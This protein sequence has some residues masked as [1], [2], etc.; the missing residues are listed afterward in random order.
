M[1][2]HTRV[3]AGRG[4]QRGFTLIEVMVAVLILGFGLLGFA[5]LQTMNVRFV[6]SAN[7]RTQ[8]TNLSYEMLDQIRANRISLRSYAGDYVAMTDD[9]DCVS[10]RGDNL[11]PADFRKDWQC[12][13]GKALGGHATASVVVNGNVVN[14][15]M[16]WD[17]ERWK[18]GGVDGQVSARTQL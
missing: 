17:D 10:P 11:T 9:S 12:R 7:F 15:T 13:M 14:V 1:N 3:F 8:A 4:R 6:Q 16:T 18:V 5:L 2:S